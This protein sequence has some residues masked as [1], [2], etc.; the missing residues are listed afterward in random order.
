[1]YKIVVGTVATEINCV[2]HCV[3]SPLSSQKYAQKLATADKTPSST[4]VEFT[5]V[6]GES[7]RD[8]GEFV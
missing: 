4:R 6:A 5:R 8:R 1:M 3:P 7:T 2:V